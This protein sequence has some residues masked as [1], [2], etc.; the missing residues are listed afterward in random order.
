MA[1]FSA[2]VQ[3]CQHQLNRR[4]FPFGMNIDR[5][6]PAIVSHRDRSIDMNGHFDL[7]TKSR[8]MFVD[9]VIDDFVNQVMQPTLIRISNE[10]PG[11]FPDRLEAFELV[12]LRRVIFLCCG[13][14]GRAAAR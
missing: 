4:H 14:S 11:P 8:E 1:K 9:G 10:H 2:G 12:D 6:A 13:D 5:N 7:C 3:I